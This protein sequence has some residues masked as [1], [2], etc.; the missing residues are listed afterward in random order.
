MIWAMEG[1]GVAY[2]EKS[3][4][5]GIDRLMHVTNLIFYREHGVFCTP[6]LRIFLAYGITLFLEITGN[7]L[8]GVRER[9]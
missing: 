4:L 2:V 6:I 9:E 7:N 5:V 1:E 8:K 3:V